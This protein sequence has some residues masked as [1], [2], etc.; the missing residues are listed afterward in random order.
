VAWRT[1]I[2]SSAA[3]LSAPLW[4]VLAVSAPYAQAPPATVNDCTFLR[5]PLALRDCLERAEN[6]RPPPPTEQAGGPGKT[7]DWLLKE[8]RPIAGSSASRPSEQPQRPRRAR[9][10]NVHV[11]Q[12]PASRG[13][14]V[15]PP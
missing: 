2:L 15:D 13:R 9:R 11:E 4:P 14:R 7:P 6:Q 1:S 12:V 3:L 8:A 5:E 10:D